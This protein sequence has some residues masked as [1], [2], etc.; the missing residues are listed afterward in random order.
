[1]EKW[2]IYMFLVQGVWVQS[3]ISNSVNFKVKVIC[4]WMCRV[5]SEQAKWYLKE[6]DGWMY[7]DNDAIFM[8]LHSNNSKLHLEKKK[9][10]KKDCVVSG[11]QLNYFWTYSD[12]D[13]TGKILKWD[14]V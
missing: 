3:P 10:R 8:T 4:L 9:E 14:P 13:N 12:T 11:V 1:M 5:N 6:I 2:Y 7:L